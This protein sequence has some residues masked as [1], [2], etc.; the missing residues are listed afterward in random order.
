MYDINLSE[1]AQDRFQTK[2]SPFSS[3]PLFKL[4]NPHAHHHCNYRRIQINHHLLRMSHEQNN[5]PLLRPPPC[6]VVSQWYCMQANRPQKLRSRTEMRWGMF[7]RRVDFNQ[8]VLLGSLQLFVKSAPARHPRSMEGFMLRCTCSTCMEPDG[9]SEQSSGSMLLRKFG[10]R[11]VE[12]WKRRLM[13]C[14]VNFCYQGAVQWRQT[15]KDAYS[16]F[17]VRRCEQTWGLC[18]FE[19]PQS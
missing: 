18:S 17:V 11:E 19:E 10:G 15:V 13:R 1:A 2:L 5:K 8:I 9:R 6:F 4:T 14:A 7:F 12:R 16:S 3:C